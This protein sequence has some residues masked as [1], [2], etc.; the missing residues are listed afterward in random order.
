M[1]DFNLL[2]SYRFREYL[3]AQAEVLDL[4]KEL[5]DEDP[6]VDKT[7]V[8]GIIGV[9]TTLPSRT[10]V[11]K[12]RTMFKADSHKV[13]FAIKWVPVDL[14]TSSALESMIE[15]VR[16]IKEQIKGDETWALHLEKR[17]YPEHHTYKIVTSLAEQIQGNVNLK[18]PDKIVRVDI[19]GDQAGITVLKPEEIFSTARG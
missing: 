18:N 8:K 17:K 3:E 4:L 9:K 19:I 11:E 7:L 2:V 14:W 13:K 15:A 1:Y 12:I 5:G 6:V 10:V 16:G